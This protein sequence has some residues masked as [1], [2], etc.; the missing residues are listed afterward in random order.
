MKIAPSML[1]SDFTKMGACA[2]SVKDADWL[3]LDIMDGHFVPNISFGPDVVRALR[4]VSELFF[5]VHLML[6]HPKQYIEKF[7]QAGAELITFHVECEDDIAETIA[8]IKKHGVKAGLSVK[9]GTPVEALYPYLDDLY[10]VLV[11][12][13]EPG[14]GGQKFMADQMG[15]LRTLRE[16]C[17]GLVLEVDGG[18]NRET[19]LLCRD[20]GADVLV[21]GTSVFRAADIPA[22]IRALRCEA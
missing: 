12:T 7:V 21:A 3:H 5:D 9:P 16:K 6:S 17:P 4:P 19:A 20:A 2:E 11:M 8:E 18:V 10:L 14:F 22:E 13:V 1:A 15:K